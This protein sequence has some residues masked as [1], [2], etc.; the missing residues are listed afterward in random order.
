M[1]GTRICLDCGIEKQLDT[2]FGVTNRN[3]R[4]KRCITCMGVD[5]IAKVAEKDRKKYAKRAF[6]KKLNEGFFDNGTINITAPSVQQSVLVE[7]I[8]KRYRT[9]DGV[10][11]VYVFYDYYNNAIYVGITKDLRQRLG[12]HIAHGST[13]NKSLSC[14]MIRGLIERVDIMYVQ[15]VFNRDI[16]ETYLIK[17]L[18]P[19]A[20]RGKT[21]WDR[22]GTRLLDT[23]IMK[24]YE[25]FKKD[26]AH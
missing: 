18:K 19:F 11:G 4:Y 2:E 13:S 24:Q 15:D 22:V 23:Q 5:N 21:E 6:R 25:E 10:E 12:A 14:L 8:D 9:L 17:T 26:R 1:E 20:N 3:L 16:Y 7:D